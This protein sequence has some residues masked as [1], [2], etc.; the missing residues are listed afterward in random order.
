MIE[1]VIEPGRRFKLQPE[2]NRV[3]VA[4]AFLSLSYTRKFHPKSISADFFATLHQKAQLVIR[5]KGGKRN[6]E[7][8]RD[9]IVSLK[10]LH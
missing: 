3:L 6:H 1:I 5:K 2:A 10:K 7:L 4:S 8:T 9:L